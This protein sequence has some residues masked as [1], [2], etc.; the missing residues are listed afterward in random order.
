MNYRS[1]PL[2]RL[3]IRRYALSIRQAVL[4]EGNLWFPIEEFLECLSELPGN[5]DFFFEFM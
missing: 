3:D 1:E 4:P 2:S 5:E